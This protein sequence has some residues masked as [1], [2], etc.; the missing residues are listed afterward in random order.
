[1]LPR[2]RIITIVIAS[3][4]AV[5]LIAGGIWYYRN[6]VGKEDISITSI[7]QLDYEWQKIASDDGI[8]GE[9]IW[10]RTTNLMI[11]GDEVMIPSWHM[12]PGRLSYQTEQTS[13]E[14]LLEDQATLLRMY[15]KAS[16]RMEA[17]SLVN[18]VYEYFDM[19]AQNNAAKSE[20]LS[21][22]C[23]Y[24]SRFGKVSDIDRIKDMIGLLFEEDGT[25]KTEVL[26]SAVY[27]QGSFVS[28]AEPDEDYVEG[29][30]TQLPGNG[31][32]E[33][34]E[35][36]GI[37][38][39]SVDLSLVRDLENAELLPEGAFQ[40]NLDAVLGGMVSDDINLYAFAYKYTPDL[41][42]P[43]SYI[44]SAESA[45]SVSITESVRTMRHLAEVDQLPV[46]AYTWIKNAVLN[47]GY[48]RDHYYYAIGTTDGDEAMDC[49]IDLMIVSY[50]QQD[51]ALYSKIS[52]SIG[53]RVATYTDSP[54]LS[55]VY[56]EVNGR[57]IVLASENLRL[58]ELIY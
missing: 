20:W 43:I 9:Y 6:Y 52:E 42:E 39:S 19:S 58:T 34:Q 4:A 21:A 11:R 56:R 1:M 18:R 7:G 41:D 25:Y 47:S 46:V 29:S 28:L 33:Q 50:L 36:E 2:K 16:D 22:F 49:Y 37:R 53:R 12:I 57:F 44:Y 45:N 13:D 54:A 27:H 31:E 55:M 48:L 8:V 26:S 51:S 14:Y 24:Y 35:F 32:D 5:L 10:Q 17:T 38:L 15:V 40:K 30:L 3:L 23:E